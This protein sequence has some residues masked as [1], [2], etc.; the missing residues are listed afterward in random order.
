[1]PAGAGE[2]DDLAAAAAR[3][4]G[5]I[6][7]IG[8][9]HDNKRLADELL[10]F[11]KLVRASE[12]FNCLF[13]EF[14]TDLQDEFDRAVN[15][16]DIYGLVEEAYLPMRTPFLWVFRRLGYTSKSDQ[17]Y[18]ASVYDEGI[19]EWYETFPVNRELLTYLSENKIS[20]L[21][22]D[23]DSQSKVQLHFLFFNIRENWRSYSDAIPAPD[24]KMYA[25]MI[26]DGDARNSIMAENIAAKFA[27]H[28][29]N[30]AVVVVGAFHTWNRIALEGYYRFSI[31]AYIPI[32]TRLWPMGTLRSV[33]VGDLLH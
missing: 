14:P 23:A 11:L 16:V 2:V 6:A 3:W 28:Q 33:V 17:A 22:V 32:Q 31:E 12:N 27:S 26:Q 20:L 21:P 25:A 30:K 8:V 18:I 7:I 19:K 4:A 29:C 10:E 24:S 9:S 1:L 15:E 5:P 13:V